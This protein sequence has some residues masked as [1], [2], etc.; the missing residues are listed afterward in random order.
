M[1]QISRWMRKIWQWLFVGHVR[2]AS[3]FNKHRFNQLYRLSYMDKRNSMYVSFSCSFAPS[4]PF[5][6]S[7]SCTAMI[8]LV[9]NKRVGPHP[10]LWCSESIVS[11]SDRK[12]LCRAHPVFLRWNRKSRTYGCQHQRT[13]LY[14]W[15]SSCCTRSPPEGWYLDV[16]RT[17]LHWITKQGRWTRRS[18]IGQR[19]LSVLQSGIDLYVDIAI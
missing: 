4:V 16:W 12:R 15:P 11:K 17:G 5:A 10:P 19:Y 3:R 6:A 18:W 1:L 2:N 8:L 14:K 7:I 13:G 9:T